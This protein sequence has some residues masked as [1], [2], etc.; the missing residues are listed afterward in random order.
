MMYFISKWVLWL[1]MHIAFRI[2]VKGRENV[3]D[4]GPVLLCA[5]H[6]SNYDPVLLAVCLKRP[7]CFI[8]KKE[9]FK[10][11]FFGLFLRMLRTIPTDRSTTDLKAYRAVLDLLKKKQAV[12]IFI[13][14]TRGQEATEAKRGASMF[15]IKGEAEIIPIGISAN[16]KP[17][18]KATVNIGR[19]LDLSSY[20][21]V[22]LKSG[23]LDEITEQLMEQIEAL[24]KE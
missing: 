22:K 4:D 3:P 15:A 7:V 1:Y 18:S 8:A 13:Q 9:L 21:G 17:F 20:R 23:L 12:G 2:D 11:P 14:G 24:R 19:Q 16:Y 6:M 10:N 5:N